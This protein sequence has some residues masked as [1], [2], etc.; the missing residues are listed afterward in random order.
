LIEDSEER[1]I[2]FNPLLEGQIPRVR[3]ILK[4]LIGSY[5]ILSKE[6]EAKFHEEISAILSKFKMSLIDYL[7]K[8]KEQ[9]LQTCLFKVNYMNLSNLEL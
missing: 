8:G 1:S 4:Q 5:E 3:S 7:T 6:A 2:T 9:Q